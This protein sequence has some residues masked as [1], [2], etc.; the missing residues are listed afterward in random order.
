M[1]APTAK[2]AT[3]GSGIVFKDAP[4]PDIVTEKKRVQR[5]GRVMLPFWVPKVAHKQL[6]VMAAEDD[7]TQQELLTTALNQYFQFRGKPPVA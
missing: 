7:T 5:N 1:K 4:E 6:R 2:R 3:I